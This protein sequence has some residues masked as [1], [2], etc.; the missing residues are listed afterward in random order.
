MAH[1]VGVLFGFGSLSIVLVEDV[2]GDVG[3]VVGK[4]HF[5]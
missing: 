2:R 4:D 3:G 5:V 1:T